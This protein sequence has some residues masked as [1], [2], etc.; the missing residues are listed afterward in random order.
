[1]V[2]WVQ[3]WISAMKGKGQD[4]TEMQIWL[5]ICAWGEEAIQTGFSEEVTFAQ[6]P[7]NQSEMPG[8]EC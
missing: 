4:A 2:E 7:E 1:M 3:E 8:N 5:P 6:S